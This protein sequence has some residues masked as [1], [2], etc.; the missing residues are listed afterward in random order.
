MCSPLLPLR[1]NLRRW[2]LLLVLLA[3]LLPGSLPANA[4]S[5]APSAVWL[6][7]H[8]ENP[9]Y[10]LWQDRATVLVGSGEHYGAV[11]N[12]DFDYPKYLAT[13]QRDGLNHTRIFL[14]DYVERAGAF[15]I[16]EDTIAPAPGRLL[17]PWARSDTPGYVGGGNKFDLDRW[18]P[19]FFA[20]LHAFM[21]EAARREIVVEVVLFFVGPGW[22]DSPLNPNNNVNR[23]TVIDSRRYLTLANG[24]LL[25]RQ[26][27]YCR[28]IVRELQPYGN[29]YYNLCN[30]PW[31]YNQEKPG[32]A[33]QP[34]V[35]VKAWI[36]R[37]ADWVAAEEARLPQPHLLGVDLC[38]QGTVITPADQAKYFRRLALFSV[39]YDANAEILRLNPALPKILAF[40]ETGFNGTADDAY[41]TQGW[42]FLL[43]GGA[44]YS[45]LDFSFTVGHEDGTATPRFRGAS[46]DGGGSPALRRQLRVLLDFMR[47]LPVER[48]QPDN[49]VVVGGADSWSALAWTG[50]AYAVW[51]PGDGPIAPKV[52]LPAGT[53]RA[54]WV[55]IL[56]GEVTASEISARSWIT[57]LSGTRRGG[58]AALR[59]LPVSSTGTPAH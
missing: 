5:G 1:L 25:A 29:L 18:D 8:P 45:H 11:M 55:D 52:S 4:A 44:L 12:A 2:L 49:G 13:V 24:N 32:F 22:A 3:P 31:F 50:H 28:K 46:Y 53:W 9:R 33:S 47:S 34:P 30:E 54:E 14:G 40:N 35:A 59:I 42:R 37:V 27:A 19:A 20:R 58:G 48:M 16:V 43:S 23:T 21:R 26:E 41:R 39:H 38:N 10:F 56:S 57:A 6:R 15:G 17:V 51:F 7:V 36:R